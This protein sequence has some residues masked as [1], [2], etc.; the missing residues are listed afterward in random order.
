MFRFRLLFALIGALACLTMAGGL[1]WF[2]RY[3]H[4]ASNL[5]DRASPVLIMRSE[6]SERLERAGGQSGDV[7]ISLSWNNRND[8]DLSCVDPYGEHISFKN[9]RSRSGGTL[10]VDSNSDPTKL[11]T[12]PVENIRWPY[13]SAPPGKY[14]VYVDHFR[15]NN[16]PDPTPF[17]VNILEKGRQHEVRGSLVYTLHGQSFLKVYEFNTSG[18]NY[19]LTSLLPA[20]LRAAL[21]TGIWM[22]LLALLFTGAVGMGQFLFFR[23]YYKKRLL[24]PAALWR[25]LGWGA[26]FGL[27]AGMSG[28]LL[29]SLLSAYVPFVSIEFGRYV[30]WLVLGGVF[31]WLIS[32]RMPNLPFVL[33]LAGGLF[34]GWTAAFAFLISLHDSGGAWGRVEGAA[35]LGAW[36]GLMITLLLPYEEFVEPLQDLGMGITAQRLRSQRS[37]AV[38]RLKR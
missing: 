11:T 29:F 15:N 14:Q 19:G 34:G 2:F 7:Q 3:I 18:D 23:R 22:A 28:Q 30:G 36:L 24:T 27:L 5:D 26:L 1:E 10:D 6:L 32:R 8:L 21:I 20:L 17:T 16:D 35:W 12:Q 31:G 25:L 33:A 9:K 4:L 38:G 13:G 37:S